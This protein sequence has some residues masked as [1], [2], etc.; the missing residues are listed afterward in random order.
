MYSAR[1]FSCAICFVLTEIL[2]NEYFDSSIDQTWG[3]RRL[4]TFLPRRISCPGRG[5]L[6]SVIHAFIDLK[7][8]CFVDLVGGNRSPKYSGYKKTYEI[9][10][11]LIS[12]VLCSGRAEEAGKYKNSMDPC[13]NH[14]HPRSFK[15]IGAESK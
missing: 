11:S 10:P 12:Q 4:G 14:K 2:H 7:K 3:K 15:G 6:H 5:Q 9:V 8:K 13:R 1:S